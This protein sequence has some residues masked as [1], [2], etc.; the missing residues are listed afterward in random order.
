M[1]TTARTAEPTGATDTPPPWSES[2]ASRLV[3]ATDAICGEPTDVAESTE[4]T[5]IE[6]ETAE[7]GDRSGTGSVSPDRT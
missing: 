4:G 2:I 1:D 7:R 3:A 6:S 5:G